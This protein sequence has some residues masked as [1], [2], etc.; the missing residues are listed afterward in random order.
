[1][2]MV[3]ILY[4]SIRVFYFAVNEVVREQLVVKA[5]VV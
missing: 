5:S 4:S 1:M 2:G 3:F